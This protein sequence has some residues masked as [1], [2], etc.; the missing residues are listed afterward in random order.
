MKRNFGKIVVIG[1]AAIVLVPILLYVEF[2][3]G[4][5]QKFRFEQRTERYLAQTYDESMK[6]VSTRYLW[7]NIEPLVAT[8]QPASDPSLQFYVYVSKNREK[9]L[10]DDYATTLWKKQ[11][12]QEAESLLQTVQAE[13]ARFIDIDFSCCKVAEYDYASIQGEVPHYGTTGLPFDLVVNMERP[14]EEADLANMYHSVTSLRE[15]KSLLLDKLIFRFPH[16]VTGSTVSFEIPGEAMD[17]V[18]SVK[19]IE[20]YTVTRFPA[21]Y[22]AEEIRATLSWNEEKSE[23][24]FKREDAFL[25]VRSWGNE[26]IWNGT[27]LDDPIGAYIGDSMELQVPVLLIER[28]FDQKLALWSP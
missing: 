13:Y 8:V 6:V 3:N 25:V 5:Y 15:S 17:G 11:A 12:K 22:I 19:E 9:G 16:P 7:D 14:A 28:T 18:S 24:V 2:Q 1:I 27:P 26:A 4:F 10:S 20:A 21:S 23:V